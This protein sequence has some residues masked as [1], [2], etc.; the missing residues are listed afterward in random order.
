[1]KHVPSIVSVLALATLAAGCARQDRPEAARP[2]AP[3]AAAEPLPPSG[4]ARG[5]S[6]P[7]A[8]ADGHYATINSRIGDEEAVWHLRAALNVAALSCRNQAIVDNYN[9]LLR[10]HKAAFAAAYAA[11]T[12]RFHG[13]AALD[14]HLTK[15]YNFFAQPPAQIAFCHAATAEVGQAVSVPTAG[16]PGYAAKAVDR[17]EA[18]VLAFYQAY[19]RYRRDLAAWKDGSHKPV[20]MIASSSPSHVA[21]TKEAEPVKQASAAKEASAPKTKVAKEAKIAAN[22]GWRI[23]IGAFS[24]QSAAEAA[25]KRARTQLPSLAD[26]KPSYEPV[27]GHPSL[28]RLRVAIADDRDGAER[29]CATATASGVHCMPLASQG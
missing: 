6:L 3:V 12:A 5:L 14:Q 27:P 15:L 24:G 29:L 10:S 25:W 13:G 16:F 20:V 4:A 26:Y 19:E 11:E 23:Q 7:S 8:D 2:P 18:P 1:M 28:V 9:Q 21:K 17:M 22:S